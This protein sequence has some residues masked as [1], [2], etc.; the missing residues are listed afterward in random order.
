[1]KISIY[2]LTILLTVFL[3]CTAKKA[4]QKH[5]EEGVRKAKEGDNVGAIAEFTKVIEINPTSVQTYIARAGLK[6]DME[7]LKGAIA[8]LSKA[9]ALDPFNRSAYFYRVYIYLDLEKYEE[10]LADLDML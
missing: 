1:M 8:D 7:D 5:Y 2:I 10:A 9:I 4:D 3:G 6:S